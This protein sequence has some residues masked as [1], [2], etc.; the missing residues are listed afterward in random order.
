[1]TKLEGEKSIVK[2][3]VVNIGEMM[4]HGEK[5][6]LSTNIEAKNSHPE[7]PSSPE[8]V[9]VVNCDKGEGDKMNRDSELLPVDAARAYLEKHG[10]QKKM[11]DRKSMC[12]RF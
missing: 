3:I 5:T 4:M 8:V 9:E 10:D 12:C 2:T 6:P 7:V 11:K 1:M